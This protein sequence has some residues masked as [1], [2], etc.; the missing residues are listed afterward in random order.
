[1]SW[2]AAALLAAAGGAAVALALRESLRGAPAL[3]ALLL[4][5][6]RTLVR[7]G[8]DG[9]LPTDLERRR[10]GIALGVLLALA[11]T[12]LVG[13]GPATVLALA[14]PALAG[15][16]IGRRHRRYRRAVEGLVAALARALADALVAGGSL[17]GALAEMPVG[18][19]GPAGAELARVAADLELGAPTREALGGMAARVRSPAIDA[20]VRTALSQE[21]SGGD[22]ADLLR[23]HAE[24]SRG[25]QRA[26]AEARSA[27]AQARLT[28]GMVAAM[29]LGAALLVELITPGFVVAMLAEP[30][31]AVLLGLAASLQLGGY[32]LIRR[33]GRA[34]R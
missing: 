24:A 14:G 6:Y 19:D 21:R 29:P 9:T 5:A 25:R 31:A 13:P 32:L 23:R 2:L 7:V 27:T 22:L 34:E 3:A 20:L 15:H 17:R 11:A 8:R 4:G 26:L 1:L 33:L 10:V 30:T 12:L 28:G 16:L 18:F